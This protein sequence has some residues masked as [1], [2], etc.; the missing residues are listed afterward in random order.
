M[1]GISKAERER[2]AAEGAAFAPGITIDSRTSAEEAQAAVA[3]VV[4]RAL[5]P[6]ARD[7][8]QWPAPHTADVHPV[9]VKNYEAAGWRAQEITQ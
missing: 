1:A 9:E 3:A 6:M 5:V 8:E 7:A 2:R 4:C